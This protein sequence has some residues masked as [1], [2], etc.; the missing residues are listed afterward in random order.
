VPIEVQLAQKRSRAEAMLAA[1]LAGVAVGITLPPKPPRHDRTTLLYPAQRHG[2]RLE[3]GIY[4]PGSHVLE[5]IG[6]C[7]IQHRALTR[8]GVAAATVLRD[9]GLP[10]YDE[11]TGR[12]LVRAFRARV[13]PGSNEL[14][15]GVVTTRVEF[16]ERP[17]LTRELRRIASDLRDDQGRP[18]RLVGIVLNH[19]PN[20]GNVL[21]GAQQEVL[22][23]E[24]WQHDHV[25][26]LRLRVSFAS[27][28]QHHRHA[29]AILFRP[30]LALLGPLAGLDV[31]DGYG[32][33]GAFG[34]RCLE[35]GARSVTA[36]ES[37]PSACADARHNLL[38]NSFANGTVREELF[39]SQPLPRCDVLLADPPRA[40]LQEQGAAAILACAPPRLLLVSCA[41]E[42]LARDLDRLAVAYRVAAVQ[43]CDLFP[44]TDHVEALTLLVRRDANQPTSA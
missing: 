8:L 44:H 7:R 37:S 10:V 31:V 42:S 36:I 27:F 28:Y 40:G 30:A 2:N 24:G 15:V 22:W 38:A 14:M 3:L 32:G 41:L 6:D 18:L 4:R 25:A 9:L 34:L 1:H 12:G 23:G 13:M 20:P 35:A 16:S 29:D 43:L 11:A 17:R 19:N 26:G 33:I 5:P 39:G 21:L